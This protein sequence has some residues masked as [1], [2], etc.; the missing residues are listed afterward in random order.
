LFCGYTDLRYGK[1][2][3]LVTLPAI[4]VGIVVQGLN[5]GLAGLTASVEGVLVGFALFLVSALLGRIIGGGDIK[6]L[7]AI[8]ALQGPAF[9][10]WT[11]L[12]GSLLGAMAAVVLGA[13]GGVLRERLRSLVAGVAMRAAYGVPMEAGHAASGPRIPYAAAIAAG[14]MLAVLPDRRWLREE[15]TK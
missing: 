14:V 4:A 15:A 10:A 2:Y 5:G 8:G 9:L 3:N 7:M 6:L 11:L 1:V 12:Y 13:S